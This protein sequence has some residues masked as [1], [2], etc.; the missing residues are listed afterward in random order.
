MNR[1]A[2]MKQRKSIHIEQVIACKHAMN[3]KC[4]FLSNDC[5]FRHES[6]AKNENLDDESDKNIVEKLFNMMEKITKRI[7]RKKSCRNKRK[8][9]K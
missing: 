9:S 5:S 1:G 6:E 8:K 3:G 7:V 2:F 4:H